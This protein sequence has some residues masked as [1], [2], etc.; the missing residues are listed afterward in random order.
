[1]IFKILY[2]NISIYNL[3]MSDTYKLQK[4]LDENRINKD[5]KITLKTHTS[6]GGIP[7]TFNIDDDKYEEFRK[8]YKN[9]VRENADLYLVE[10]NRLVGPLIVDIDFKFATDRSVR[11]YTNKHIELLIKK[12]NQ[13]LTSL[14]VINKV[15]LL[16]LVFE[17]NEPT[18]EIKTD[19]IDYKDGFH[20][21]YPYVP[22]DVEKRYYVYDIMLNCLKKDN[23]FKDL[24]YTNT[25]EDI[26]DSSI[27][28][29]NGLLMYGSH[30]KERTPYKLT[31][32][33][34]HNIKSMDIDEYSSDDIVDLT[35]LRSYSDDDSVQLIKTYNYD[36]IKNNIKNIYD[37]YVNK[38]NKTKKRDIEILNKIQ[39]NKINQNNV[40]LPMNN[41]NNI[42]IHNTQ[43]TK[44]QIN[45]QNQNNILPEDFSTETEIDLAKRLCKI[46][47]VER[48][49]R[50]ND[51]VRVGW[52]LYNISPTLLDD[53]IEFSKKSPEKY[54]EGCCEKVWKD[55]KLGG[56]TI[57]SLHWWAKQDN[58]D[59]YFKIMSA[60]TSQLII[61]ASTGTHDDIANVIY[62]LYKYRFRCTSV[63]K[64][65]W[66]EF[67]NHRWQLIDDGY[68]LSEL[69]SK[70]V[71]DL[72]LKKISHH[73]NQ[74]AITDD[75]AKE[76]HK[77]KLDSYFAT[78]KNLKD[79]RFKVHVIKSCAAKFYEK[80]FVSKLDSKIFLLGFNNG[81]YDFETKM[82]RDG[83][84]DD[85]LTFSVGYDYIEYDLKHEHMTELLNYFKTIH[86]DD[87]MRLFVFKLISTYITGSNKEQLFI[88]WTGSGSNGKSLT[89][90]LLNMTFGDYF[91]TID[92]LVLTQA[93]KSSSSATP[94]L[95]N[96]VGKRLVSLVEPAQNDTIRVAEMKKLT[97]SDPVETRPLWCDPFTFIPQFKLLLCCNNKPD[98]DGNDNGT[99]RRITIVSWDSKFVDYE[100]K[101]DY[102]VKKINED[103][104]NKQFMYLKQTLMWYLINI[105]YP[106]YE[107]EGLKTPEKV[108]KESEEY[109]NDNDFFH[110]FLIGFTNKVD[111]THKESINILFNIFKDWFKEAHQG[112]TCP[113]SRDMTAYMTSVGYK[114]ISKHFVVGIEIKKDLPQIPQNETSTN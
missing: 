110:E 94:E 84:P 53:Y 65:I 66:Y 41:M 34:N 74:M 9:A 85:Y 101:E 107:K 80:N 35:L 10:R 77:K 76:I 81:V 25:I 71:A 63:K 26:L 12:Y 48:A 19:R 36:E 90:K 7:G 97:G 73:G 86:R 51:W 49:I 37:S 1:M 57:A 83:M 28:I 45:Q 114:I 52:V 8:L 16:A 106:L 88:I 95:A 27:I 70:E 5:D 31:K 103:I 60:K 44:Q 82:F 42:N 91:G 78:Y 56:Y 40:V 24:M 20:I 58:Y 59:E 33:Y 79:S 108:I 17:K 11:Q 14:F 104:I 62:Q 92:S 32:V 99:W 72:F 112:S 93:R 54:E 96:K 43:Q 68:S 46:L 21:I 50:F 18:K 75:I 2:N 109:R 38:N 15:D 98:T 13:I 111:K 64:N 113:S 4:F 30:K 87:E 69:I 102:E 23:L 22:L 55:A 3:I 29:N 67:K 47:S 100:P 105:I 39:N 61:N 6:M 89:L